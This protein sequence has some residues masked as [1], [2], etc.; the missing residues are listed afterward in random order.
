MLDNLPSYSPFRVKGPRAANA[1][2]MSVDTAIGFERD[3]VGMK[4]LA[5]GFI[6]IRTAAIGSWEDLYDHGK[7]VFTRIQE[8]VKQRN[9]ICCGN[10]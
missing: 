3:V 1:K 9:R 6:S 2:W 5:C 4:L 7:A 10:R 8:F